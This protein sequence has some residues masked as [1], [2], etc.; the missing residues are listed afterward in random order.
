M[1]DGF[2]EQVIDVGATTTYTRRGG[3]GPPL[4]LLHGFPETHVMWH[5]VGP[6]LADEFTV[7]CADLRG[8]GAS[9]APA[10]APGHDPYAKRAMAGDLVRAMAALGF[11]RFAVAAPRPGGPR[12]RAAHHVPDARA[13]GRA[14]RA[15]HMVR[16]RPGPAGDLARLGRR[17]ARARRARRTLLPGAAPRA[18]GGGAAGVLR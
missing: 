2:V 1:F 11:E 18:D 10:S 17:R 7:V 12:G 4:L 6:A 9:G 16:P 15:R 13:L 3:H 8:Y 5:R 14:R